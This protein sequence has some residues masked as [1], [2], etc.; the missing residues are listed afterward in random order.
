M[1]RARAMGEEEIGKLL[2][3]FSLPA[4]AGMM[5]NALYNVIDSIFVGR[6][7]GEIGLAAVSVA[8]PLM[9][10]FMGMGLLIGIGSG[11]IISIKLGE[12]N[13]AAAENI[14]GN[15]ILLFGVMYVLSLA[16]I[17]P[18]LDELLALVGASADILPHARQ[19]T[20]II[21]W[22][23]IFLYVGMGMN[24]VVRAEGNL[25]MAMLTMVVG[26]VVNTI[27]NPLF[28]FGLQLGIAGSAL[29]TVIAQAVS[30]V[31]IM[32]YFC[33][34]K[35][36][37]HIRKQTFAF[38]REVVAGIFKNGL[39]PFL[40]QIAASVVIIL[41]NQGLLQYAGEIALAAYGVVNRVTM[42]ILMPLFGLSQGMQ[43]IIG[44]N[45]GAKNYRRVFETVKQGA[46]A[47]SAVTVVGFIVIEV[48][49]P[50]I[51]ALFSTDKAMVD[52][53]A[54]AM[55][56]VLSML[57]IVGFQVVGATL[58]QAIGKAREAAFLNMARQ[59]LFLIPLLLLLPHFWGFYGI[60]LAGPV[61][62]AASAVITGCLLYG[63]K[64]KLMP[65]EWQ[66]EG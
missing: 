23:S 37:L 55:R 48:F 61:S 60:L 63:E 2:W 31:W 32:Q 4:V 34:G 1:D 9:M 35:S 18:W 52:L 38:K 57:P 17:L 65:T 43:P 51:I 53:G 13:K 21:M 44:Y 50:E 28:I 10:L 19:F 30:A 14:M 54:E 42:L 8:F 25:K 62:D 29:A 66:R 26:A 58:F 40:M 27:L 5:V 47:A 36:V 39:P 7:V 64:K 15:A 59:V 22:G 3:K 12:Q 20:T 45:Y 49:A 41:V 33:S 46:F 24:N 11:T 6:G 56:I 16:A